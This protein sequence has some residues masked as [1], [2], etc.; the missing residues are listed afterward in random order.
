MAKTDRGTVRLPH[1]IR[2]P[3]SATYVPLFETLKA[4]GA[5]AAWDRDGRIVRVATLAR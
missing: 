4:L 2:Q 5:A 1:A 3:Q